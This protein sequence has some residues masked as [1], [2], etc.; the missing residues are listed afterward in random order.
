MRFLH[1]NRFIDNDA[2]RRSVWT[3]YRY[4]KFPWVRYANRLLWINFNLNYKDSREKV[5]ISYLLFQT[6]L[7]ACFL[8]TAS[9][10]NFSRT[11]HIIHK[12]PKCTASDKLSTLKCKVCEKYFSS[13]QALKIHFRL[14]TGERPYACR[15][16]SMRFKQMAHLQAHVHQHTG[17]QPFKCQVCKRGFCTSSILRRHERCHSGE[18]PF[19]CPLCHKAFARADYLRI[20]E[21]THSGERPYICKVCKKSFPYSMGLKEHKCNGFIHDMDENLWL[22]F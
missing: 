3:Q 12:K 14:H 15:H 22:L 13:K 8:P 7:S 17:T 9:V 16:C 6:N 18:K 1:V 5:K 21:R 11:E 10:P 20:H 2:I 4:I 19:V